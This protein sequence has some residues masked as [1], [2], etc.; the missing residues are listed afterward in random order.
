[1]PRSLDVLSIR[2]MALGALTSV[3]GLLCMGFGL[4]VAFTDTTPSESDT[5]F[6]MGLALGGLLILGLGASAAYV[7]HGLRSQA[8]W[9]WWAGVAYLAVFALV[10]PYL[11]VPLALFGAWTLLQPEVRGAF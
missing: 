9:G 10:A 11:G 6:Q 7:G 2:L 1:M 8:R 5:V 4:F 3:G